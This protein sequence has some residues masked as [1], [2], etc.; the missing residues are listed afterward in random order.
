MTADGS[1]VELG[2][3]SEDLVGRISKRMVFPHTSRYVD[4][5]YEWSESGKPSWAIVLTVSTRWKSW[6]MVSVSLVPTAATAPTAV[7]GPQQPAAVRGA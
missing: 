4:G 7:G 5:P 1:G 6:V 2:D 3:G